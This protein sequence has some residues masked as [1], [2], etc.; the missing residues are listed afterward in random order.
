[1]KEMLCY[2]GYVGSKTTNKKRIVC[3]VH[4][5]VVSSF[6]EL[7]HTVCWAFV[8]EHLVTAPR[9]AAVQAHVRCINCMLM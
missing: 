9:A 8:H 2:V 4:R 3:S 6:R 1:M 7:R 5:Q